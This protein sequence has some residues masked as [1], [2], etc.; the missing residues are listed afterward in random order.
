MG[1]RMSEGLNERASDHVG[2][3]QRVEGKRET[4]GKGK[5]E[6]ERGQEI[7]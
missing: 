7:V 5:N 2:Q 1:E 4:E 3:R 6:G